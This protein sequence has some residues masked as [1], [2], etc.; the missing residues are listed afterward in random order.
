MPARPI[1]RQRGNGSGS[2]LELELDRFT[3]LEEQL[4]A[5]SSA[6][7]PASVTEAPLQGLVCA[8]GVMADLLKYAHHEHER[9]FDSSMGPVALPAGYSPEASVELLQKCMEEESIQLRLNTDEVLQAIKESRFDDARDDLSK[10]L[11]QI[12]PLD[13]GMLIDLISCAESTASDVSGKSIILLIGKTGAGK[14]TTLHF[15][16]GSTLEPRRTPEGLMHLFV[17]NIIN[18]DLKNVTTSADAK[19]DTRYIRAVSI[20]GDHLET[21]ESFVVCDCPGFEDTDGAEVDI[22]NGIGIVHV[23]SRCREVKPFVLVSEKGWGDRSEGLS[24]LAR[25]ITMFLRDANK[26]VSSLSYGFT[27]FGTDDKTV[28]A[29]VRNKLKNATRE[30]REDK[31]LMLLL[32]D[33]GKKLNDHGPLL[34]DPVQSKPSKVIAHLAKVPAIGEPGEAFRHFVTADNMNKLKNQ[35]HHHH[36]AIARS[37]QR[38]DFRMVCFKLGQLQALT[39]KLRVDVCVSAYKTSTDEVAQ[40]IGKLLT[41]VDSFKQALAEKQLTDADFEA[42]FRDIALLLQVEEVRALHASAFPDYTS[43][44]DSVL[45]TLKSSV[46]A[47]SDYLTS[48]SLSSLLPQNT[49]GFHTTPPEVLQKVADQLQKLRCIATHAMKLPIVATGSSSSSGKASSQAAA[50]ATTNGTTMSVASFKAFLTDC[51]KGAILAIIK[52][53][54]TLASNAYKTWEAGDFAGHALQLIALFDSLKSWCLLCDVSELAVSHLMEEFSKFVEQDLQSRLEFVKSLLDS[55][56]LTRILPSGIFTE[57]DAGKADTGATGARARVAEDSDVKYKIDAASAAAAQAIAAELVAVLDALE[58]MPINGGAM[59]RVYKCDEIEKVIAAAFEAVH[60]YILG[61]ADAL[62]PLPTWS[63]ETELQ[64]LY[65]LGI[66]ASYLPILRQQK[67]VFRHTNSDTVKLFMSW[68][69]LIDKREDE[70]VRIIES[71]KAD[72]V[73]IGPECIH[74]PQLLQFLRESDAVQLDAFLKQDKDFVAD[75]LDGQITGNDNAGKKLQKTD[76]AGGKSQ[77]RPVKLDVFDKLEGTVESLLQ[78]VR[79]AVVDQGSIPLVGTRFTALQF[80]SSCGVLKEDRRHA[81]RAEAEAFASQVCST[82]SELV[83]QLEDQPLSGFEQTLVGFEVAALYIDACK[84]VPFPAVK[85]VV[86][87]CHQQ[88]SDALILFFE[89]CQ[90]EFQQLTEELFGSDETASRVESV[91]Q[92]LQTL[93]RLQQ[94]TER[95]HDDRLCRANEMLV[96]WCGAEGRLC[97]LVAAQR[98]V[99]DSSAES[100]AFSVLT[101][102]HEACLAAKQ[103]DGFLPPASMDKFSDLLV[104]T[105]AMVMRRQNDSQAQIQ[106]LVESRKFDELKPILDGMADQFDAAARNSM[107]KRLTD[108]MI[109]AA[110]DLHSEAERTKLD[111]ATLPTFM[112]IVEKWTSLCSASVISDHLGGAWQG[113][114]Q[115]ILDASRDLIL[116]EVVQQF[117]NMKMKLKDLDFLGVEET[118]GLVYGVKAAADTTLSN[119]LEH[120][121]ESMRKQV[122]TDVNKSVEAY[123]SKCM[124]LRLNN[125]KK[126]E[127]DALLPSDCD[128]VYLR[129]VPVDDSINDNDDENEMYSDRSGFTRASSKS[130]RRS[131]AT[132]NSLKRSG[133]WAPPDSRQSQAHAEPT[134]SG[135]GWPEP[136]TLPRSSSAFNK[137]DLGDVFYLQRS[138][139]LL[140]P[141]T[142]DA[143]KLARFD[144]ALPSRMEKAVPLDEQALASIASITSH[145]PLLMNL[146][147]ISAKSLKD[148]VS[149]LKAAD[150]SLQASNQAPVYVA[151]IAGLDEFCKNQFTAFLMHLKCC[152]PETLFAQTDHLAKSVFGNLPDQWL[153]PIRA[154]HDQ[155]RREQQEVLER[156]KQDNEAK[157]AVGNIQFFLDNML[158][159]HKQRYFRNVAQHKIYI[160][161]LF[162]NSIQGFINDA[163]G[164]VFAVLD[165]I[166]PFFA[167]YHDYHE[168][169][170]YY[171]GVRYRVGDFHTDYRDHT[172]QQWYQLVTKLMEYIDKALI[173]L[174]NDLPSTAGCTEDVSF[175]RLDDYLHC[176]RSLLQ[177]QTSTKAFTFFKF[178]TKSNS[179]LKDRIATA[180]NRVIAFFRVCRQSFLVGLEPPGKLDLVSRCAK[181]LRASEQL[182]EQL[183]LIATDALCERNDFVKSAKEEIMTFVSLDQLCNQLKVAVDKSVAAARPPFVEN[184]SLITPNA[185]DRTDYFRS[186]N[187]AWKM[188]RGVR[189]LEGFVEASMLETFSEFVLKVKSHLQGLDDVMRDKQQRCF[190]STNDD[191]HVWF[192]EISMYGDCFRACKDEMEDPEIS[193]DAASRLKTR[194]EA[195]VAFVSDMRKQVLSDTL[196]TE[197]KVDVLVQMK[198]LSVNVPS[199]KSEVDRQIDEALHAYTQDRHQ[200]DVIGSMGLLLNNHSNVIM[201][202]MLVAEHAAF[203]GYSLFLRNEKTLKFGVDRVLEEMKKHNPAIDVK[204]L[205]SMHKEFDQEYWELVKQALTKRGVDED[206]AKIV[207]NARLLAEK[208]GSSV[209]IITLLAHVFA[210]WTLSNSEH[211]VKAKASSLSSSNT[212]GNSNT[213][214]SSTSATPAAD[215]NMY[216]MQPHAAQIIAIFRLLCLDT[217]STASNST[218]SSGG[219]FKSLK[220]FFGFSSAGSSDYAESGKVACRLQPH[221]VEIKTG[222]GKSVTLAATASVLALMGVHVDCACYSEYLSERDFNAFKPLFE[223]FGV[224]DL[225]SYGT[226]NRLCEKLINQAGDVRQLVSSTLFGKQRSAAAAKSL[227]RPHV[228]LIDEVDVFFNKDFYGNL[229]RPLTTIKHPTISALVEHIWSN[230]NNRSA[231]SYK[232]LLASD[233]FAKCCREFP[234]YESLLQEC[235]KTMLIDLRSYEKHTYVVF[236]G[237]IGYKDQDGISFGLSYG[238][239]TMFAWFKEC[240]NGVVSRGARDSQVAITIDCGSFSY[241]E[242]PKQYQCVMGVS[243]TLKTLSQ[244]ERDLLFTEYSISKFTYVP[245][246]YGE[247]KLHFLG[248][249]VEGVRIESKAGYYTGIVEEIKKN[250]KETTVNGRKRD[251]RAVLVFFES[252]DKLKEFYTSSE[253]ATLK[254]S[255]KTMTE[256]TKPVDKEGL[257]RQAATSGTVMLLSKEFGRG[258]DFVCY[259]KELDRNGG[260]HVMQ[261]FVS[262]ELSEETQIK[263]RTARQGA[264]GSFGMV[265]LDEELEKYG[266]DLAAIRNMR[267]SGVLYDTINMHRIDC[268]NKRYPESMRHVEEIKKDHNAALEF[269]RNLLAGKTAEISQFLMERNKVLVDHSTKVSRTLCLMDATGSMENLL[270]K[271]KTAVGIMFQC[272]QDVLVAKGVNA[273]FE[274]QFAT[275]RDYNCEFTDLLEHSPWESRPDELR[276]FMARSHAF[277]GWCGSIDEAVEVGLHYA[278][279]LAEEEDGLTQVILV[280]DAPANTRQ[281]VITGREMHGEFYWAKTPFATPVFTDEEAEKLGRADI[282]VHCFYVAEAA[283]DS[284]QEIASATGGE[285][286]LLDV[287]SE[288]GA[289]LLTDVV[290]ESILNT[291]GGA[292]LVN[293]YRSKFNRPGYVAWQ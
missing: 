103:L 159:L 239:K 261:T 113:K 33:M 177:T 18:T 242:I 291:V 74:L 163:G 280:G 249:T 36:L 8:E 133:A 148:F 251:T 50:A 89:T 48:V 255:T 188:L 43:L 19:S 20:Q 230:R 125:L 72:S 25:T 101:K 253:F 205:S 4:L 153:E 111:R 34:V 243:G 45:T 47:M 223:A 21:S 37:L 164:R 259:D 187:G 155:L 277:G 78:Q 227:D 183:M 288:E 202:G 92:M 171:E 193:Q 260:T 238:Y 206:M 81:I 189:T 267:L 168:R 77:I 224:S 95:H 59:S 257:I 73:T 226:F 115:P 26:Y 85:D 53:Q 151:K 49:T 289:A 122:M 80:L 170:R 65:V 252:T 5:L 140:M 105:S 284:F 234:G 237:R 254:G 139:S 30:E 281:E 86:S 228:L 273:P 264:H 211:Y 245:S 198:S 174:S 178:L 212:S 69:T 235:L 88:I 63:L 38:Q 120:Q 194:Q 293:A 2:E 181:R 272:V 190:K 232:A 84:C 192:A 218:S 191:L 175:Q 126:S 180:F 157:Q 75:E 76:E 68:Q 97:Q 14:S 186:L 121:I 28:V 248:N 216:L 149:S 165:N 109:K 128:S 285:C 207:C 42:S 99:L 27:K 210:Y 54:T 100:I 123:I 96:E 144:A 276:A 182:F 58:A 40:F 7:A 166:P 3:P 108:V 146:V 66:H 22:S 132:A 107:Q 145:S 233:L 129:L 87:K 222:E 185:T 209:S 134:H 51:V 127:W 278:N 244:P 241:A 90:T 172:I 17:N 263:G 135:K 138:T 268:F 104:V 29:L 274:I 116:Q 152:E 256:E 131:A 102:I 258:T 265:L 160:E 61:F 215:P 56:A 98:K 55:I 12:R 11:R 199:L 262:P 220:S 150:Q 167:L 204:L 117:K 279:E 94:Y 24:S 64:A 214:P 106:F 229:Y 195:T 173:R 1:K 154:C 118:F 147:Q 269:L 62:T 60:R 79:G 91:C 67:G 217:P 287:N 283:K 246:V 41:S 82:M 6:A 142:L 112:Y 271:A 136:T 44:A 290:S 31:S 52:L 110:E 15:L 16:A 141:L 156:Q 282:P 130:A 124:L 119:E 70:A 93:L 39:E 213:D 71:L 201:G 32:Q 10:A 114:I 162:Q 57:V 9:S 143:D 161:G 236:Q 200:A 23:V 158:L 203:Q 275:Y 196:T 179:G 176:I 286:Y 266:L 219:A 240:D 83:A 225:I 208:K 250:L 13:I 46:T 221:L 184:K 231:V 270:L 137:E 197:Q 35:M 247:N 169:L 292:D